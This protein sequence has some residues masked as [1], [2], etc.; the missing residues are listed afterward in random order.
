VTTTWQLVAISK[1][2]RD[3][4]APGRGHLVGFGSVLAWVV[5]A[6]SA[7][8]EAPA[9]EQSAPVP[10]VDGGRGDG[11]VGRDLVGGQHPGGD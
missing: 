3:E 2:S 9:G 7:A 4:R 1:R 5:V 6:F 10:V 11:E 8:V